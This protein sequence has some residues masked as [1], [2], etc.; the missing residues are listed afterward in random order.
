MRAARAPALAAGEGDV[1]RCAALRR[2]DFVAD[3]VRSSPAELVY[4]KTLHAAWPNF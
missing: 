3:P 1:E 2:L 4:V